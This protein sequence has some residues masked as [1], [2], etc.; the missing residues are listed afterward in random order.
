MSIKKK[1][2]FYKE[3]IKSGRLK[4]MKEETIWIYQYAK[5]Y[6][7]VTVFY[8]VLGLCSSLIGIVSAFISK[9]LV[10]IITG[11]KTGEVIRTFMIMIG[12]SLFNIML[13]QLI[14]YLSNKISMNVEVQ[15]KSD[16]FEKILK[17]EWESL[18]KYHTGDLLSR[19]SSDASM[20]ANGVLSFLPNL[21]INIF[22]FISAFAVVVYNDWT[23]ALFALAGIPVSLLFSKKIMTR[24][25]NNNRRSAQMSARLT[26]FNQETFANIQTI[27]AFDLI[28]FY[29][30]KQRDLSKETIDMRLEFSRMSIFTSIILSIVSLMVSYSSYGWG[31]YRVWSGHITYGTMTMFLSMAGTLTGS[32]SQLA[33]SVPSIISITT[34]ARRLMDIIEMP[35]DDY[36][37]YD[38]ARRFIDTYSEKGLSLIVENLS[39][40]YNNSTEVFHEA[41]FEGHPH[42]IIGLV[43]PSG[44]GKTTMLRLLLSLLRIKDGRAYL[45]ADGKTMDLTASTRQAFSYVP[46]GNTIFSGT[47]EE[48][49]RNVK[50]DASKEEIIEALKLS[51]AWEFVEKLPDG[52]DTMV[53]ERG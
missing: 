53:M 27:K 37:H 42:E 11:H 4:Q 39:Y 18:S 29:S 13:S 31:I 50:E 26:G 23:F 5:K 15:I 9:D 52:I 51:C 33:T 40:S 46:Q 19:W 12:V 38:E 24:M 7:R 21:I 17:T 2:S 45:E 34:S 20:I 16:I 35:L 8:T 1:Y 48:N 43:G 44:E 28:D 25:Q 6:R 14:G 49:M 36:D 41:S 10:D 47:I 32:V 3:R 30:R 22:K